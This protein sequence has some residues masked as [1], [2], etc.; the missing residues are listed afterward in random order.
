M[1]EREDQGEQIYEKE[2]RACEKGKRE[3]QEQE[4]ESQAREGRGDLEDQCSRI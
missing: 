3:H 1:R 2:E 4:R